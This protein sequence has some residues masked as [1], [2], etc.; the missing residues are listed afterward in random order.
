MPTN[1]GLRPPTGHAPGAVIERASVPASKTVLFLAALFLL[2]AGL[3]AVRLSGLAL[4]SV[5]P[6]VPTAVLVALAA[7]FGYRYWQ[8][9]R[10]EVVGARQPDALALD[11]HGVAVRCDGRS[12][13][14]YAWS[15]V[16]R[17]D[18]GAGRNAGWLRLWLVDGVPAPSCVPARRRTS[19]GALL[20]MEF[21]DGAERETVAETVREHVPQG[22]RVRL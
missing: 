14:R 4:I 1:R 5:S 2:G 21:G 7:L 8:S 6:L 13:F 15:Q 11:S 9:G 12:P 10:A 17:L 20:V 16:R 18:A 3:M 19:E 22:V